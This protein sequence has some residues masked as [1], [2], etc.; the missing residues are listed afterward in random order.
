[1]RKLL[2][3]LLPLTI[4]GC[5]SAP[6]ATTSVLN[7]PD[8]KPTTPSYKVVGYTVE[9]MSS[10]SCPSAVS[11]TASLNDD[12]KGAAGCVH[13]N[14]WHQVE[15]FGNQMAIQFPNDAWG[16][17]FLSLSAEHNKDWPRARWMA[18]L[19]VKK[20]PNEG[21][22]IYQLGRLQWAMSER[23]T[24]LETLKKAVD[25][26]PSLVEAHVLMGQMALMDDSKSA[27]EKSFLKAYEYD[28][29]NFAALMGLGEIYRQNKKWTEAEK[30]LRQAVSA[31]PKDA[32]ARQQLTQ[33]QSILEAEQM[34]K[35]V[36]ERQPSNDRK[37]VSK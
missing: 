27:A 21:L 22:T 15:E 14:N 12:V 24:A 8:A 7:T 17:Y 9:A 25:K 31:H 4:A 16:A 36:S 6:G 26:N 20:A 19:A 2:L 11:K 3:I 28:S 34:Q 10:R 29:K 32:E 1:M 23:M 30:Y 37:K 13:S 35:K 18:E 5:A 33:I